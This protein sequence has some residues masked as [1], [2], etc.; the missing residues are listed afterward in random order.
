MLLG[1]EICRNITKTD[2]FFFFLDLAEWPLRPS[3]YNQKENKKSFKKSKVLLNSSINGRKRSSHEIEQMI[4]LP[5]R[6][7][8]ITERIKKC[9]QKV[10]SG[11]VGFTRDASI[12]MRHCGFHDH[13]GDGLGSW[14]LLLDQKVNVR[15]TDR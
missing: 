7:H 4:Q 11:E 6:Q 3:L 2:N 9:P 13:G 5:D 12:L 14:L 8:I 10:D 15:E 1:H